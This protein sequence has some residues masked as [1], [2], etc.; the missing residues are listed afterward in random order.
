[1]VK[2]EQSLVDDLR[3]DLNAFYLLK[4]TPP[5]M[6]LVISVVYIFIVFANVYQDNGPIWWAIILSIPFAAWP[7]HGFFKQNEAINK[8][9][10]AAY[11]LSNAGYKTYSDNGENLKA[12]LDLKP[13][14]YPVEIKKCKTKKELLFL[15][16]DLHINYSNF[17]ERKTYD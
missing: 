15:L 3:I 7:L 14:M 6:S 11:I 9:A 5:S 8:T 17:P 1:M 12:A 16:K 4:I 10:R 13:W 2:N